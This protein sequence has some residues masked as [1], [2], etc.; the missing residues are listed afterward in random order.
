MR[1]FFEPR[2][3]KPAC[4]RFANS[5]VIVSP[6]DGAETFDS[7]LH[8]IS[9]LFVDC[10][11]R[12]AIVHFANASFWK[13]DEELHFAV[14]FVANGEQ[15]RVRIA[16]GVGCEHAFDSTRSSGMLKHEHRPPS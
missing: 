11:R 7:H 8:A 4:V 6:H 12:F 13:I 9:R 14:M 16:S 5:I 10:E 2:E 15:C 1:L 3:T